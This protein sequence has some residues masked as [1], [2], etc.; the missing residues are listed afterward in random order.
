MTITHTCSS[1]GKS[2]L[3]DVSEDCPAVA[4]KLFLRCVRCDACVQPLVGAVE[5]RADNVV[6]LNETAL[7]AGGASPITALDKESFSRSKG[8]G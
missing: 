1:C 2:M 8:C 4:L 6:S 5:E 3:L 7:R